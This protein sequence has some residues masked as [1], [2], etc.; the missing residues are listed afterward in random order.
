MRRVKRDIEEVQGAIEAIAEEYKYRPIELKQVASGYRFQIKQDLSHWVSRLF[1]EK[2]PKYSRAL[3]ETLAI[4]A[5]RQPVTRADIEDIRDQRIKEII[6][7]H[8]ES[9]GVDLTNTKSPIDPSVWVTPIYVNK[10]TKI[11]KN[12]AVINKVTILIKDKTIIPIG[13]DRRLIKTGSNHHFVLYQEII[14]EKKI[15]GSEFVSLFEAHNRKKNKTRIFN[16]N[17][18]LIPSRK[19]IM[20]LCKRDMVLLLED[21]KELLCVVEKFSSGNKQIFFRLHTD[22]NKSGKQISKYPSTFNGKKVTLDILGNLR[23]AG[24]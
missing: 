9:K 23:D 4:I 21:G 3:L 10:K 16:T 15:I 8:I 20:A 1:E 11:S 24:D 17:W 5:Y 18:P 13:K 2:P 14:D 7:E 19:F 12:A 22:S 6:L